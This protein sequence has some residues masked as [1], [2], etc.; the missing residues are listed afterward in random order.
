MPA[1]APPTIHPPESGSTDFFALAQQIRIWGRELGFQQVGITD[2]DPGLHA[3][4]LQDWL[5][6]QYHG[7]MDYMARHA[8][9]R[10]HPD[11]LVPGALRLISVRMDYLPAETRSLD[12]LQSP[13]HAYVSRYA[14]G[15]DYH[16]LIRKRL[17]LLAGQ[18]QTRITET[19][20]RAFVVSAP[21]LE[22]A[23][24]GKA[25]L[26]WIGKNT[27]L[28][29][30][31]A[32]SWFFLGELFTDLPLPTDEPATDH[33]GSCTACLD[34]CPT[35]AFVGANILDARRCIS[36]LTIELKGPIP[37]ELRPMMGNRIYGCDDCQLCCPWNKF[38]SATGEDAFSPRHDLDRATLLDL[39][40]WTEAEFLERT[41]GSP[42]RRTGYEGWQRNIAVAL[43][44][45][46]SS[47][48][49]ISIL[50]ANLNHPSVL[51]REHV[52]W[53]LDQHHLR[54]IA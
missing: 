30:R 20:Y 51:V 4:W 48:E 21:V 50:S 46:S 40:S 1:S 16:K 22:R 41:L 9:L 2:L 11:T 31:R 27:M 34:I 18:I 35:R 49:I 52:Q 19:G 17:Q 44:N 43:G 10:K 37:P 24:A 36:Y 33:C 14:L 13:D 39:F 7:E 25:G 29:N 54:S 5:D 28:I 3:D 42:I 26:G 23:F 53:A 15:R 8:A 12:I 47:P 6:N 45:A 38:A 32:G